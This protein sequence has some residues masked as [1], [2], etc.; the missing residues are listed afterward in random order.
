MIKQNERSYDY[1]K[2]DVITIHGRFA[3]YV[4]AMWKQNELTEDSRFERLLDLYAVAAAI[5]IKERILLDEDN[6]TDEKRTIQVEQIAKEYRRFYSLLQVII[7]LDE[8]RGLSPQD[9]ARMAFE[10]SPK[11]ENIYRENMELFHKYARGG[12]EF[13]YNKL[14]ARN[15]EIDDEFEVP[16]IA[17]IMAFVEEITHEGEATTISST[18]F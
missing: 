1:F 10:S 11:D 7:L 13:L 2:S 16:K 14:V 5:G 12:I 3:R 9:K 8:S 18:K 4:D 15:V 17:N 6:L